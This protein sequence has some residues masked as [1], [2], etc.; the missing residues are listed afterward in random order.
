MALNHIHIEY[1]KLF[2]TLRYHSSKARPEASSDEF[3]YAPGPH[4]SL[5]VIPPREVESGN[6]NFG[7]AHHAA[8]I[9]SFFQGHPCQSKFQ[10]SCFMDSQGSH[11]TGLGRIFAYPPMKFEC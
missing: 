11:R 5:G 8:K 10:S 2:P 4:A 6:I 9:E 7:Y 3:M 1:I